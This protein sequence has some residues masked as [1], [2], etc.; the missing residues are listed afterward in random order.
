MQY[1][2]RTE[3]ITRIRAYAPELTSRQID[4]LAD[5]A[6]TWEY[7][8]GWSPAPDLESHVRSVLSDP[9]DVPTIGDIHELALSSRILPLSWSVSLEDTGGGNFAVTVGTGDIVAAIVPEGAA[10]YPSWGWVGSGDPLWT[11]D[12]G[13]TGTVVDRVLDLLG[14]V[15]QRL[16][17][18]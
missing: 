14:R 10:I 15:E 3:A 13:E 2:T 16:G 9:D 7:E 12:M 4:L 1:V 5:R 11:C 8:T 17:M 18:R 6:L